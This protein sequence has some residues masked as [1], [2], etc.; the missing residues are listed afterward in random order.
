MEQEDSIRHLTTLNIEP[1]DY[2]LNMYSVVDF[3][4]HKHINIIIHKHI[5][6][7]IHKHMLHINDHYCFQSGCIN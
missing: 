6:T 2:T 4:C 1:T 5:N 3:V 7:I